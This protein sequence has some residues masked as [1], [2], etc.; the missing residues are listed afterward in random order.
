MLIRFTAAIACAAFMAA[1][2]EP[3]PGGFRFRPL[4]VQGDAGLIATAINNQGQIVGYVCDAKRA[5]PRRYPPAGRL[6]GVC[7]DCGGR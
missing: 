7:R 6:A 3:L 5:T 2:A 4:P 1:S